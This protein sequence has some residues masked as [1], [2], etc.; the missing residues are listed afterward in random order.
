MGR[1]SENK[2]NKVAN[3]LKTWSEVTLIFS[4][5]FL[6]LMIIIGMGVGEMMICFIA[7]VVIVILGSM[8]A[9]ILRGFSEVVALLEEVKNNT[10]KEKNA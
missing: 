9:S 4:V 10:S 8:S 1:R 5:A 7:G 3:L 6:A 2:E